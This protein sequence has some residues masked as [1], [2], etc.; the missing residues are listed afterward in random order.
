MEQT[1]RDLAAVIGSTEQTLRLWEK[2]RERPM[3]RTADRLLRALYSDYSCGD[4]S[5]RHM[6]ERLAQLNEIEPVK[7]RFRET[8]HGW[9]PLTTTCREEA[10]A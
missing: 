6:L 1:Q 5:V 4:G 8:N 2:H 3:P 10:Y 9:K 7:A